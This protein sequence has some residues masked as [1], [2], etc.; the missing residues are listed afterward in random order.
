MPQMSVELVDG[1]PWAV[2]RGDAP[3]FGSRVCQCRLTAIGCR[4]TLRS[5]LSGRRAVSPS[6][7]RHQPLLRAALD[8]RRQ[9]VASRGAGSG[10][11][12]VKIQD[13]GRGRGQ[14]RLGL[15]FFRWLELGAA[16]RKSAGADA[17][18]SARE[19]H[20]H[21]FGP[22]GILP[23]QAP[24][25]VPASQIQA[26]D[27]LAATL[28]QADSMTTSFMFFPSHPIRVA[29]ASNSPSGL[30]RALVAMPLAPTPLSGCP[31]R[32]LEIRQGSTCTVYDAIQLESSLT[33]TLEARRSTPGNANQSDLM[34]Q[35]HLGLHRLVRVAF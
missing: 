23:W 31:L 29:R 6:S 2:G 34:L 21:R 24:S 33:A 7:I 28:D 15:V 3:A 18:L 26:I 19:M 16:R 35:S 14:T 10:Q 11:V 32:R 4:C 13:P 8:R 17:I 9:L 30:S 5:W 1:R 27:G 25:M 12:K 20:I 22:I